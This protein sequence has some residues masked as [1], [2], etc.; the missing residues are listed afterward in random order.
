MTYNNTDSI[1]A[2]FV[3]RHTELEHGG[4]NMREHLTVVTS[5]GN[6]SQRQ[7]RAYEFFKIYLSKYYALVHLFHRIHF[8]CDFSKKNLQTFQCEILVLNS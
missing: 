8:Q 6:H 4:L 2:V 7:I 3:P 5:V 1:I